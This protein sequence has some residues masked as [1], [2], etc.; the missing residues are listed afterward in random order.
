MTNTL[1]RLTNYGFNRVNKIA[2]YN[3]AVR[4][5]LI[6]VDN[7]CRSAGQLF[8]RLLNAIISFIKI[9]RT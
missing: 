3:N 8:F 2:I 1:F 7:L 4:G 9:L 5:V 6:V